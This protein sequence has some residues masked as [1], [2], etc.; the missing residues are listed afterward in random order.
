M[1]MLNI[2]IGSNI[3]N[4]FGKTKNNKNENKEKKINITNNIKTIDKRNYNIKKPEIIKSSITKRFSPKYIHKKKIKSKRCCFISSTFNKLKL[5][6][7][8]PL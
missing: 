4:N 7:S 3:N 6:T 1:K 2:N 5:K 8:S